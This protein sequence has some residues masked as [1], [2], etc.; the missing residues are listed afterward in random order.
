MRLSFLPLFYSLALKVLLFASEVDDAL[1]VGLEES[2]RLLHQ[3]VLHRLGFGAS[4]PD[5]LRPFFSG[6]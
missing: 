1:N 4:A 5:S 3:R 6:R 2:L